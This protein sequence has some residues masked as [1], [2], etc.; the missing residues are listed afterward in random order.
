[1]KTEMK[2]ITIVSI[3]ITIADYKLNESN[4]E[5]EN[6]KQYKE[7]FHTEK[8]IEFEQNEQID[9]NDYKEIH[10]TQKL[11]TKVNFFESSLDNYEITKKSQVKHVVNNINQVNQ[12]PMAKPDPKYRLP[13]DITA[14]N[15]YKLND[16]YDK[17]KKNLYSEEEDEFMHSINKFNDNLRQTVDDNSQFYNTASKPKKDQSLSYVNIITETSDDKKS[18]IHNRHNPINDLNNEDS[19]IKDLTKFTKFALNEINQSE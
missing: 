14:N 5:E 2:I 18:S 12:I 17:Y 7:S 13:R 6:E 16:I 15:I 9:L 3:I 11:Q 10:E 8:K 4:E 1:M 19:L